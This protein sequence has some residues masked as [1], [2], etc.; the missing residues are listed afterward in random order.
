[1]ATDGFFG[2]RLLLAPMAIHDGRKWY[3]SCLH[4]VTP[5]NMLAWYSSGRYSKASL[6]ATPF[7]YRLLASLDPLRLRNASACTAPSSPRKS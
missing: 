7:H 1:M 6:I 4:I 3:H 5:S 2:C